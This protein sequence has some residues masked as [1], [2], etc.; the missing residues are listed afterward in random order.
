MIDRDVGIISFILEFPGI[1]LLVV[2]QLR[3]V[4][5]LVQVLEYSREDF[6]L[7]IWQVDSSGVGLEELGFESGGEEGGPDEDFFVA[8]KETLLGPDA[9]CYDG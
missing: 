1:P 6:G 5:P 3:V 7:F 8:S 9:D 2:E 4:V